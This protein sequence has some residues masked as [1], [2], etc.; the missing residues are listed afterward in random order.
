M[1]GSLKRSCQLRV[2]MPGLQAVKFWRRD[3]I[4]LSTPSFD[5]SK[6]ETDV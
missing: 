3:G 2:I 1:H 5:V 6:G 4:P